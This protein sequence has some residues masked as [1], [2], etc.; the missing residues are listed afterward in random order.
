MKVNKL[1]I[2]SVVPFIVTAHCR[3]S[4]SDI[5]TPVHLTSDTYT[6]RAD[7]GHRAGELL[8]INGIDSL[9]QK[10]DYRSHPV[11]VGSQ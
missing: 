4:F 7:N 8:E 6:A 10:T 2:K 9:L 1:T 11:I 3:L 5:H